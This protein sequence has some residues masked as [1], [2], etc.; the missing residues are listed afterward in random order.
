MQIRPD[1]LMGLKSGAGNGAG[2]VVIAWVRKE[3]G[4]GGSSPGCDC[5]EAQSMVFPSSLGGVPVF[6]RPMG[7]PNP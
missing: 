5:S 6:S 4:S 2:D 7:K 1:D 3:K